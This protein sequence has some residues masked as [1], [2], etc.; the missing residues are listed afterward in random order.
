M[1][2]WKKMMS[3]GLFIIAVLSGCTSQP[4]QGAIG[5]ADNTVPKKGG[6]LKIAISSEPPTL[7]VQMTTSFASQEIGYHIYEGLFTP[8]ANYNPQP[9]LAKDYTYD[10]NSKSY[11]INL[12]Q[13]I[14]FHDGKDFNADD[15]I[16]SLNRW[17]KLNQYGKLLA[18]NLKELKKNGDYQ[19]ILALKESSPA[20]P[21]LLSFPN[22]GAAIYP[23]EVVD[24]AGDGEIKTF[25]GT[26][27]YK[28][29]EH[30]PDQYIKMVR[31]EQYMPREETANGMTGKRTAYMDELDFIP[32]PEI[33]VRLDGLETGQF[34]VAEEISTDMYTRVKASSNVDP[35]IVKPYWWP[36]AVFNNKQGIFTN[37]KMR[38]AFNAALDKEPIMKAAFSDPQFYRLDPSLL[39]KEVQQWYS[40]AG[41]ELYNQGN[42]EKSK[43]LLQEAGYKGEKIRWL[44]TKDYDYLYKIALVATEQLKKAGFNIDLQVVDWATLVSQRS[45]P[46]QYELYS[47]SSTF[48]SDP[49][50]A[51]Y[52]SANA[53]G[54]W[55][56]SPK[57][58]LLKKVSTEM[59]PVKR[60]EAWVGI[61]KLFYEEVPIVKFGDFFLLKAKSKK[62][63]DLVA[64]PYP[65][66]WNVW[67]K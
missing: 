31:Y 1:K 15:V 12:R 25:I 54:W 55:E 43:Q 48:S 62:V 41:K 9:M 5:T 50:G 14:K 8:D 23:K 65:Y 34:D 38:Q 59:D 16:A 27:P 30:K 3:V 10:D 61:Q 67:K 17:M 36:M 60:K 2:K 39:Q 56:S 20:V 66:Y 49:A 21:S 52:T 37:Q 47:T 53:A 7:D 18:S 13:G 33:S 19:I 24:A 40:D 35:V 32:T 22:Q 46:D 11:T 6:I 44:T 28:F 4:N 64:T 57:E 42:I 58:E 26:G 45:K 51:G 63:Q 29:Q